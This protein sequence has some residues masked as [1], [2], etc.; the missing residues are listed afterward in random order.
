MTSQSELRAIAERAIQLPRDKQDQFLIRLDE[1]GFDMSLLPVVPHVANDASMPLSFAQKRLYLVERTAG[2]ALYNLASGLML[3]GELD[4]AALGRALDMIVDRHAILRTVYRE[5]DGV[6]MQ[7]VLPHTSLALSESTLDSGDIEAQLRERLETLESTPFA[8]DHEL[9]LRIELYRVAD[10]R[11]ALLWCVHHIAFDA[12]SE[13][14]LQSELVQIYTALARGNAGRL[15]A[16]PVQYAD[17]AAW[18]GLWRRSAGF[19]R[20]AD[21]WA[22]AL[23][24]VPTTLELPFDRARPSAQ[25]YRHTGAEARRTLPGALTRRLYALTGELI[26]GRETTLYTMLQTAFGWLLARYGNTDDLCMASSIANRRRAELEPLIGCLMN[27]LAIRHRVSSALTFRQA[28]INA[29]ETITGAF[30][31]AEVPFEHVL[32]CL[33]VPR[34]GSRPPLCQILFVLQNVPDAGALAL[35]GVNITPLTLEQRRAR[36]DLSLRIAERREDDHLGLH[37]EYST[38]L[39]DAATIERLLEDFEALLEQVCA[40][41]ECRFEEVVLRHAAQEFPSPPPI[42]TA[43]AA[44][45]LWSQP[46]DA[47]AVLEGDRASTYGELHAAAAS[48]AAVLD[49]AGVVAGAHVAL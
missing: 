6:P 48:L 36:F 16:L 30:E 15:T 42:A 44:T 5:N 31:H 17:Y 43:P 23:S 18:E 25:A 7:I 29:G 21:W 8:L 35:P 45:L 11:W 24:G 38:E 46:A 13:G 22:Q 32:E 3:E 2:K 47:L 40:A 39:F 34:D 37:L 41:P 26:P 49:R 14:V 27:T 33:E 10:R 1:R 19:R 9:P 28:V 12:W 4:V 20:Q